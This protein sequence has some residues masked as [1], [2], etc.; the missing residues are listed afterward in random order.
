MSRLRGRTVL[1][2]V[3][4]VAIASI[5]IGVGLF[6]A[7]TAYATF[8]AGHAPANAQ[9]WAIRPLRIAT[10]GC[11]TCHPAEAAEQ[12][13]NHHAGIDCQTCHG[14]ANGH[15]GTDANAIV[16]VA[17]PTAAICVQCHTQVEGRPASFPQVD[18]ATHWGGGTLCLRC[19]DPHGVVAPVPP[20]IPHPLQD[21]PAC[22]VCHRPDGLKPIPSGHTL[23]ADSV[24]LSCHTPM[25]GGR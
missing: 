4:V 18:L 17:E 5:A 16:K 8:G 12:A 11:A 19:H 6:V 7:T 23:V 22:T 1:K 10:G 21:L 14:P 24:C 3:L 25:V 9:T 20:Q 15:P 2:A 13:G